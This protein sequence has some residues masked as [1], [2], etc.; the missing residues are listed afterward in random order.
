MCD[1]LLYEAG[2]PLERAVLRAL[3]ALGFKATPFTEDGSE[4]DAVF[5]APEGRFIGEV[6]GKND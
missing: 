4:F 1:S 6:E 2:K 3:K 5:S